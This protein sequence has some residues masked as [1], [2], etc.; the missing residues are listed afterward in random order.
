MRGEL[1]VAFRQSRQKL[2]RV[3]GQTQPCAGSRCQVPEVDPT[4]AVLAGF[5]R[6]WLALRRARMPGIVLEKGSLRMC[7]TDGNRIG[8][9]ESVRVS[10]GGARKGLR[11]RML[12]TSGN[13]TSGNGFLSGDLVATP[14]QRGARMRVVRRSADWCRADEG[15]T[16][17]AA[18]TA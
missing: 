1:P 4:A 12:K 6:P 16:D 5:A 14:L 15:L 2:Q 13:E 18:V 8:P 9:L 10:S 17:V 11:M 7:G 3:G